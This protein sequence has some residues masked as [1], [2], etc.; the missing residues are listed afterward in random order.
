MSDNRSS[1]GGALLDAVHDRLRSWT[2]PLDAVAALVPPDSDVADLGC[3][4]GLVTE[5]IAARARHVMGVDFD[6][7]KCQMAK[8]RLARTANAEVVRGDIVEW[9]RSTPSASL[10]AIVLSDTL[11]AM[12]IAAQEAGMT[13][14]CRVLRSG[15]LVVLKIVDTEPAW[16][17]A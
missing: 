17:A 7:R 13:E 4:Q 9:L 3:G 8:L 2:A 12:P 6:E 5:L 14:A 10:D 16:K 15:G 11:S 1:R